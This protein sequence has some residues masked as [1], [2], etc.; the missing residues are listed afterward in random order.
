MKPV[1][2]CTSS[3][4]SSG[5]VNQA[6]HRLRHM[7]SSL[8]GRHE[9]IPKPQAVMAMTL[10]TQ[11]DMLFISPTVFPGGLAIHSAQPGKASHHDSNEIQRAVDGTSN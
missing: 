1:I 3:S 6:L 4:L 2:N 8:K 5:K 9:P 7:K 11:M 10:S